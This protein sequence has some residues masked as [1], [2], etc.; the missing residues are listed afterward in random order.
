MRTSIS[1]VLSIAAI[2]IAGCATTSLTPVGTRA[3][4][5]LLAGDEVTVF[6]AD[7]DVREP[8]EV[9]GII[10]YA[11]P[12]KYQV[13][14]LGDALPELL[15]RARVAGANGIIIDRTEL[16]RSGIISTGIAVRARAIRL[17]GRGSPPAAPSERDVP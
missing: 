12:G 15:D 8:F 13:L 14:T 6:S 17:T 10:D 7:T 4:R 3:Y 5:P 16:I 9:V 1:Y 2:W 11:N